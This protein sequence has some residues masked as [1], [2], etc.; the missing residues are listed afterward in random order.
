MVSDQRLHH[1]TSDLRQVARSFLIH[2]GIACAILAI[3]PS[4]IALDKSV[5]LG[6]LPL[7]FEGQ[8]SPPM[9]SNK[10]IFELHDTFWHLKQL[11]GSD[12]D[13]S[14][15]IVNIQF[16]RH[17]EEVGIMTFSTPSYSIEFL[18]VNKSTGLE[19]SPTSALS[20]S[21]KN[22]SLSQDQQFVQM[23]ETKLL[24]T[25]YYELHGGVLTFK[26]SDQ[27]STIVLNA[28]QQEGIENRRWRIA[29]YRGNESN[30]AQKVELIE[31]EDPASIVLMNGKIYGSPGCGALRGT[32]RI[33]GDILTS[34][35]GFLLAGLC[36]S[37]QFAQN[38]MVIKALKG[39]RQIEKKESKILLRDKSGKAQV[40]LAPF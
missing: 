27:H 7:L 30:S 36:S 37:Q 3:S 18:F 2:I 5:R 6:V 13:T 12:I 4:A 14:G 20:G 1:H 11:Q 24:R 34:D 29:S 31:P 40:L 25:R 28:V 21:V 19:F 35:V 38:S 16:E 23:F 26:D 15:V 10:D 22:K 33:T 39:D 8:V 32:Y 9:Q 17:S